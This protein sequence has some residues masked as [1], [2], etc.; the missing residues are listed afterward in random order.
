MAKEFD[1]CDYCIN[2]EGL[3]SDCCL[4]PEPRGCKQCTPNR[5]GY[6]GLV[7]LARGFT[8]LFVSLSL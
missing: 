7:I 5:W 4:V 6:G 3:V 2:L 8:N 1:S